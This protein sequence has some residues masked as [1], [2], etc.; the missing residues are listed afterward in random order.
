MQYYYLPNSSVEA[1]EQA[2]FETQE[3]LSAR[4]RLHERPTAAIGALGGSTAIAEAAKKAIWTDLSKTLG[5][6]FDE[7]RND[8]ALRKKQMEQVIKT[9]NNFVEQTGNPVEHIINQ[10][11]S[12]KWAA[13]QLPNGEDVV[14]WDSSA[15]H[16]A[17]MAHELGHVNM[18]H[19]NPILDPLAGLQ[20]SGIGR[21]SGNNAFAIGAGGAALGALVGRMRGK[22]LKDQLIGSGIGGALGTIGGSG[23][24]AYELG[25]ASGRALD[26][27]PED[28]DQQDAA[29]DLLRAG[30]TYG[31]A[32]P[33]T[34]AVG[35]L[36]TGAL[37]AA[38]S[39]PRIWRFAG[40]AFKDQAA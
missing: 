39:H 9:Y 18:N 38:I 17:V 13:A 27:L 4:K 33:A 34:A 14:W 2:S 28:Y 37:A 8:P 15:P 23:Q 35:A 22:N 32:G 1:E 26:Y 10:P 29:G 7:I 21:F 6:E 30:M 3:G 40:E 5:K 20:T 11:G 25:G 31:M 19:A 24:F 36:G 12:N 16:A